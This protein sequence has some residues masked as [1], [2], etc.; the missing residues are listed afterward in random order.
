MGAIFLSIGNATAAATF[1]TEPFVRSAYSQ[2]KAYTDSVAATKQDTLPTATGNNGKVLG[3]TDAGGTIG[4]VNPATVDTTDKADLQIG[5]VANN[6]A[7]MDGAGQY[8]DSG[9]SLSDLATEAWVNSQNYLTV[10]DLPA[11]HNCADGQVLT[12]AAD[13]G[14]ECNDT[15]GDT[16]VE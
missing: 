11:E 5:D 8:V 3:V 4:W 10:A 9:T 6:V 15:T 7:V 16:F 1:A 12:A 13:G 2:A 14:Y